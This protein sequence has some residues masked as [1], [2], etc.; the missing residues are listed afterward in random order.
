MAGDANGQDEIDARG[1]SSVRGTSGS[2]GKK[3]WVQ[4]E[5]GRT[6][7]AG[8]REINGDGEIMWW[9]WWP[10]RKRKGRGRGGGG[11]GGGGGWLF[12]VLTFFFS[13]LLR[14]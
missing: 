11:G 4:C 14:L 8:Q 13:S 2:E 3:S 7:R 12:H 9:R 5:L 10:W 1:K 6:D